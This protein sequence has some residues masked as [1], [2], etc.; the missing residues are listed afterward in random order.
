M[1]V[2]P[3]STA[4]PDNRSAV[5]SGHSEDSGQESLH[6]TNEPALS[7]TSD[8]RIW[9][10]LSLTI[11]YILFMSV[12]VSRTI[13]WA[14]FAVAP[15]DVVGSFLEGAFAPLAFLWLVIGYFL[16]KKALMH[17]TEAIRL[18]SVEMQKTSEQAVIQSR[19]IA[20]SEL[21]ARKD[22]FLSISDSVMQQLGIIVGFLYISSQSSAAGGHVSREQISVLWA[23]MGQKDPQIFSRQMLEI[24][25]LG[26][27]RYNYK[28]FFGTP[29]RSR[30]TE[31]F[32]VNFE[33]LL[34]AADDCDTDG[35][36]KDALLGSAHGYV[37]NRAVQV[38]DE[39]PA[40]FVLGVYDFD[41][42]SRD[43]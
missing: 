17:N 33:R 15:L 42:D 35:M 36:I 2:T 7:E 31:N 40:G 4:S 39:P 34:K 29:I 24:Q 5:I 19:A 12:Y 18:Q 20:A 25:L 10:G 28:L 23:S 21:H 11:L 6:G 26:S 3:N 14:K 43:D 13:G 22:S 41:P 27:E 32:V 16:Q 37:F 8:W 1:A 30:H 38:R 9:L